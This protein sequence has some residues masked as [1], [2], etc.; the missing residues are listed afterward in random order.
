MRLVVDRYQPIDADMGVELGSRQ[1][2]MAEYLLDAA[3]VS[4]ALK[5]V[6][7]RRVAQAVRPGVR[8]RADR[9]DPVVND[10]ADSSRVDAAGPGAEEKSAGRRSV[11]GR[12][13]VRLGMTVRPGITVR[14]GR[15]GRP[16]RAARPGLVGL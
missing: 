6:G 9:G 11:A 15:A 5:Q 7:G 3:Q 13:T 8:Y 12:S 2:G 4:T 10:A 1:R 14:P 16:G